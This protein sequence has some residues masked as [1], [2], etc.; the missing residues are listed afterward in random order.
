LNIINKINDYLYDDLPYT[1]WPQWDI[2]N[3]LLFCEAAIVPDTKRYIDVFNN[4]HFNNMVKLCNSNDEFIS[5]LNQV[6]K[7]SE[8]K[9]IHKPVRKFDGDTIDDI[10][11]I[12]VGDN[13]LSNLINHPKKF[14]NTLR[15]ILSHELVHREQQR[16]ID[17]SKYYHHKSGIKGNID[18]K[19][20]IMAY[21]RT[22][23]DKLMNVYGNYKKNVIKFLQRPKDGVVTEFD[24]YIDTF[25]NDSDTVKRLYKYM[26]E[27]T[28]NERKSNQ[29]DYN[30]N[31]IQL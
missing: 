13:V 14:M 17:W 4:K 23:V 24:M 3:P 2:D 9:F 16:R 19:Q 11:T 28:I 10:I 12:Y 30:K 18:N 25:G 5:L 27:Y 8:I 22:I 1:S 20:E 15:V 6:F 7:G 29:S 31:H 26:Y 21:A